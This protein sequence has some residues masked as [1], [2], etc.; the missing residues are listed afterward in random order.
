MK[1]KNILIILMVLILEINVVSAE[2]ISVGF[3]QSETTFGKDNYSYSNFG[4]TNISQE[5]FN[6]Y[7]LRLLEEEK[8]SYTILTDA[9]VESGISVSSY[10]VFVSMGTKNL[11]V[12]AKTKIT[13]YVNNGGT[14]IT[15][16]G[17]LKKSNSDK[18]IPNDEYTMLN[19]KMDYIA[20]DYSPH[21]VDD[22]HMTIGD[23]VSFT[24]DGY[25]CGALKGVNGSSGTNYLQITNDNYWNESSSP[26]I[27]VRVVVNFNST[28]GIMQLLDK[29]GGDLSGYQLYVNGNTLRFKIGNG[30][31]ATEKTSS[32][33]VWQ[34]GV[35][36]TI[37]TTFN[38]TSQNITFYINGTKLSSHTMAAGEAN[39]T[40][41]N[42]TTRALRIGDRILSTYRP[43]NGT[44]D[45]VFI[46]SRVYND[47]EIET[48]SYSNFTDE[49]TSIDNV[50]GLTISGC[51]VYTSV[52]N[53]NHKIW[54][55]VN[56]SIDNTSSLI[57]NY[58]W[59]FIP[60]VQENEIE[61][62]TLTTATQL[63]S[64]NY[65]ANTTYKP[66]FTKNIYGSGQAYWFAIDNGYMKSQQGNNYATEIIHSL[67]IKTIIDGFNN[68]NSSM[69]QIWRWKNGSQS[70]YGGQRVDMDNWN[71]NQASFAGIS[72]SAKNNQ[73][74]AY[75]YMGVPDTTGTGDYFLDVLFNPYMNIM[76]S[77]EYNVFGMHYYDDH[78]LC[79]DNNTSNFIAG[80]WTPFWS[81]LDTTIAGRYGT[82]G[83][84]TPITTQNH[85]SAAGFRDRYNQTLYDLISKNVTYIGSH[86]IGGIP[87]YI[88]SPID[89][90]GI[91]NRSKYDILSMPT[92]EWY[93]SAG[94][95]D[96]ID[97]LSNTSDIK[98][99][100]DFEYSEG[101]IINT[102]I[103]GYSNQVNY[104]MG[105]VKNDL[106]SVWNTNFDDI[107][108]FWR[109]RNNIRIVSVDKQSSYIKIIIQNNNTQNINDVAIRVTNV[110]NEYDATEDSSV[111]ELNTDGI[112]IVNLPANSQ[113]IIYLFQYHTVQETITNARNTN[114]SSISLNWQSLAPIIGIGL[115]I[116]AFGILFLQFKGFQNGESQV[117]PYAILL[118]I[119]TGI[120]GF[121]MLVVGNY[122]IYAIIGVTG[123]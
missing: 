34:T 55:T 59:T 29:Q 119:M 117:N 102:Y 109:I 8:I 24:D 13:E 10:P 60:F 67:F 62:A 75:F 79:C 4:I 77:N 69:V 5:L 63:I 66:F 19:M 36:Y 20:S 54:N 122:L 57:N 115:M 51:S 47:T 11:S 58:P 107:N 91:D 88:Y 87:S 85:F 3:H 61:I 86:D 110:P 16:G 82:W 12:L 80:N 106:P 41:F 18:Y 25:Q 48:Y 64:W 114:C 26:N 15:N 30:T 56:L 21:F 76:V 38:Y 49:S 99:L 90:R 98:P 72:E 6:I 78:D 9:D 53:N 121:S 40:K 68:S 104:S 112:F 37:W 105:Y 93:N 17:F 103:H 46:S 33:F 84:G 43:L 92:N 83:N 118:G 31:V 111:L 27:S 96:S 123:C 50:L 74:Y 101:F 73:M 32:N 120:V 71:G 97:A 23:N 113:S 70:A 116:I 2:I 35:N 7:W 14:L 44:I 42:E 100:H 52:E 81:K 95:Q 65:T 22:S 1:I 89:F 94:W 108:D 45:N 28:P 39:F